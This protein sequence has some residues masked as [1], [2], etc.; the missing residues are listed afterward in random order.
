MVV[1]GRHAYLVAIPGPNAA[2]LHNLRASPGVS[3]AVKRQRLEGVARELTEPRELHEARAAYVG[4]VNAADYV[5]CSLHWRGRPTRAKIQH[6]HEIW[7]E[8]GTPVM[9]ELDR[10]ADQTLVPR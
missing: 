1:T 7:F 6:L 8:G 2:W 10:P 5:E 4:T 9:V 3:L